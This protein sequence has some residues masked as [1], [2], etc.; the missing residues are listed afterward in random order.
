MTAGAMVAAELYGREVP[1]V[2]LAP[3]DFSRLRTGDRITV[4]PDGKVTIAR[5]GE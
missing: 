2:A 5:T 3:G 4:A 1:V